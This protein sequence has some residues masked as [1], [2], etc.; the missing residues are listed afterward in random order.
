MDYL[1]ELELALA[2]F[3]QSLY[4][5]VNEIQEKDTIDQNAR[6][7]LITELSSDI[8]NSHTNIM[9]I[10]GKIPAEIFT[11]TR[12]EQEAEIK[13]LEMKYEQSLHRL[14]NLKANASNVFKCL[15]DSLD[16]A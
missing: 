3:T 13:S 9:N 6:N 12:E 10:I 16:K 11:K 4:T 2:N 1:T 8:L 5:G 14:E 7:K 15:E